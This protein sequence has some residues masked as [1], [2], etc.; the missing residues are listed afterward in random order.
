MKLKDLYC[1]MV[2]LLIGSSAFA[3]VTDEFKTTAKPKTDTTAKKRKILGDLIQTDILDNVKNAKKAIKDVKEDFK[4]AK[5]KIKKAKDSLTSIASDVGLDLGLRTKTAKAKYKP[6]KTP[7]DEFEG[8]KFERRIGEYGNGNR[9]TIE[10]ISVLK[11]TDD[12]EVSPYA[13]E[14][15]WYDPKLRKVTNAGRKDPEYGELCHGPYKKY[16][17]D[18]LVEEG[19]FNMGT[20]HGRWEKYAPTED[21]TLIEKVKYKNGF[22]A[23]SKFKFYDKEETKIEEV[24]PVVYG[25]V[26]GEYRIFY[27]SGNIKE[28]GRLDDSVKVGRWREYH[29]FGT[30][31]KLKKETLFAKD[32]FDK[33]EPILLQE[34][35]DKGKLIY[36]APKEKKKKDSDEN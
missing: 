11:Y 16:I 24:I 19:A 5:G 31:G 29:E 7:K 34:R 20:K 30:G 1:I 8:I 13:K 4:D 15:W 6:K 2:F 21:F 18:F 28:E 36:E 23:D 33:T 35:D 32:K 14:I 3:Q 9:L 17:G 26:S 12:E 25:K 22:L 10:E 27:K